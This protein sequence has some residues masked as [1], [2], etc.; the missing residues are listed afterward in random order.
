MKTLDGRGMAIPEV[1]SVI[2]PAAVKEHRFKRQEES[3]QCCIFRINLEISIF[4]AQFRAIFAFG[5][6]TAFHQKKLDSNDTLSG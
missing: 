3:S 4:R 1:S 6:P 2:P 5:W